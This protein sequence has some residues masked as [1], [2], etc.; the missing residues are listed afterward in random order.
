MT[1]ATVAPAPPMVSRE[2][3]I[4]LKIIPPRISFVESKPQTP[5]PTTPE[6]FEAARLE[7]F[8]ELLSDL[9]PL[10]E[11]ELFAALVRLKFEVL[12][13]GQR[14]RDEPR[15]DM[16]RASR[17]EGTFAQA[18]AAA[19]FDSGS[20]STVTSSIDLPLSL[21]PLPD[22][23]MA[24]SKVPILASPLLGSSRYSA[25]LQHS[26]L[27]KGFI[28]WLSPPMVESPSMIELSS[29]IESPSMT[30]LSNLIFEIAQAPEDPK[31]GCTQGWK[32]DEVG[33]PLESRKFCDHC[34]ET[35]KRK[36]TLAPSSFKLLPPP[37]PKYVTRWKKP[38]VRQAETTKAVL[39]KRTQPESEV[40]WVF[41]ML[42]EF[43]SLREFI[44]YSTDE[45]AD[46]GA[47]RRMREILDCLCHR[48]T[49]FGFTNIS[50]NNAYLATEHFSDLVK[51]QVD[52]ERNP[53]DVNR[54]WAEQLV[55]TLQTE[56][57]ELL[58]LQ[59]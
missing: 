57:V 28:Q 34:L 29:V 36:R 31:C 15:H 58:Q 47:A 33:N 26:A 5:A 35:V 51:L 42:H 21:S 59:C 46:A 25:S 11:T 17:R 6:I 44:A 16:P 45:L 52:I 23:D 27:S 13:Q 48:P 24:T 50:R 55:S 37:T 32:Y 22:F 2:P 10:Q 39:T 49:G 12:Q 9:D 40:P 41:S 18:Y 20:P 8:K 56:I 7:H 19:S 1:I 14:P 38:C 54:P 4:P 43:D 53:D 3:K 30:E